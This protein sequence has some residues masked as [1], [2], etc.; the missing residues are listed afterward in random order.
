M[1]H[2]SLQNRNSDGNKKRLY[3]EALFQKKK[4]ELF[5]S[6]KKR[7]KDGWGFEERNNYV[8]SLILSYPKRE[9]D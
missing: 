8:S 9:L 7:K 3:R 5:L 1:Y 2:L 4:G 6:K